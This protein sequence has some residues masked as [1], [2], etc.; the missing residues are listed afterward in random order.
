SVSRASLSK[1]P[2]VPAV[3][4][5]AGGRSTSFSAGATAAG[6]SA[7]AAAAGGVG[8][9]ARGTTGGGLAASPPPAA[10]TAREP[11]RTTGQR[12]APPKN[13]AASA[14]RQPGHEADGRH[15]DYGIG[16]SSQG[17]GVIRCWRC[18]TKLL[19]VAERW[20]AVGY[21]TCTGI[22]G[23]AQSRSTRSSRCAR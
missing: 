11:G 22:D 23:A 5:S 10:N 12:V 6:G 4:V 8:G 20:R 18:S 9:G 13:F 15:R 17:G 14:K 1:P 19:T 3:P 2:Q 7:G 16:P 21:T